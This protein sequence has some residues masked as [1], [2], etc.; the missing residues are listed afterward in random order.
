VKQFIY[1]ND[2]VF[3]VLGTASASVTKDTQ[4]LKRKY[5][6]ADA[7]LRNGDIYYICMKAIDVDF[8]ELK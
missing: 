8:E 2:D 7:V 6:L 1:V 5:I 4:L 3:I